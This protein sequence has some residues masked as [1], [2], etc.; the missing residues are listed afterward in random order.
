MTASLATPIVEQRAPLWPAYLAALA[1]VLGVSAAGV[2]VPLH[3]DRLGGSVADAGL[4]TG[5]RFGLG[6]FFSL[7]FGALGDAWGSRRSLFVATGAVATINLVPLLAEPTG[8]LVPLYIWAVASGLA[9]SLFF[10][11]L[12]AFVGGA[13][14]GRSSGSAFGWVTLFT[15]AGTASGPL[16]AG[17]LWDTAGVA[18]AYLAAAGIAALALL[19]PMWVAPAVRRPIDLG[20]IR[21]AVGAVARD[22]AIVGAWIAALGIGLP[23]GAVFGVFPLFGGS[24]GL[25]AA[26]IGVVLGFQSLVNGASR[27]PLGLTI[28]RLR[29]PTQAMA[30]STLAYG[31][32]VAL[33]GLQR[34]AVGAA[35]VLGVGVVALAFTLMMVQVVISERAPSRLRATGLGGYNSALSAGLG[36]GPFIA[37]VAADAGGFGIGFGAVA[38]AATV[39]AAAAALA[40]RGTGRE[41]PGELG[42]RTKMLGD[43]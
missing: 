38:A 43:T 1:T 42:T 25:T 16:V 27:V 18:A 8:S 14:A 33:L 41:H 21:S 4:I 23:W 10:P 30:L 22:H 2:A 28:D 6:T 19:A 35:I 5:I 34:T 11:S 17:F 36:L 24:I 29:V 9:T 20:G 39:C 12:S 7:P 40:L 15:H 13:S 37:G 26:S 32:A 3:V 31:A